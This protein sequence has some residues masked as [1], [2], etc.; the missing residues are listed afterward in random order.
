MKMKK[1]L[2]FAHRGY[3]SKYPENTLLAFRKA[4]EAGADGIELDVWL[5]RDGVPVVI[6]DMTLERLAGVSKSVK[7]MTLSELKSVRIRGEKIPTLEEVFANIPSNVEVNV[8]IKDIDAVPKVVELVVAN[9][10]KRVLISSFYP[11]VLREYREYDSKTRLGLLIKDKDHAQKVK[12]YAES[13]SLWSVNV[14]IEGAEAIGLEN[15]IIALNIFKKM[16]LNVVLWSLNDEAFYRYDVLK[17]LVGLFEIVIVN[18]VERMVTYLRNM[19]L[20]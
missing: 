6:H 12:E 18:D 5:S 2:V 17:R 3:S 14:P 4:I 13:L 1:V 11:E 9:N 16:K 20:R 19:G 10:P 8:E 7:A 15:F